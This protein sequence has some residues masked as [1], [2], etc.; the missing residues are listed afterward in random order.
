MCGVVEIR[1]QVFTA[2]KRNMV[3]L[4]LLRP[5]YLHERDGYAFIQ[6]YNPNYT[7]KRERRRTK[8]ACQCRIKL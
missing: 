1:S 4:N 3:E 7:V 5:C 2:T 6:G 8:A